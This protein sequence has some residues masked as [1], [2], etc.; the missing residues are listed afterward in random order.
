[1]YLYKEYPFELLVDE[2]LMGS[3]LKCIPDEEQH[4]LGIEVEDDIPTINVFQKQTPRKSYTPRFR[5]N[6]TNTS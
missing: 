4:S 5:Q 1:M 2:D 3:I 6:K